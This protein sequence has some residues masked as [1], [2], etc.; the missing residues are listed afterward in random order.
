MRGLVAMLGLVLASAPVVAVA[1]PAA[2]AATAAVP[3]VEGFH[4]A[5][6]TAMKGGAKLGFAGRREGLAAPVRAAFDLP[7]MAQL[8]VGPRWASLTPADRQAIIDAFANYASQFK[9][10]GGERFA[11]LGTGEAGR[12]TVL[13]RTQ[14]V[15]PKDEPVA[16]TYR[17]RQG[18]DGQ[19]RV[20]D[21]LLDG[22]VSQ[23]SQ[24]RAE[25]AAIFAQGGA[26]ALIKAIRDR[27][28]RLAAS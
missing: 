14:L 24:R 9:A 25:F 11:T 19:W 26:P 1:Q 13:V 28:A 16:F 8:M 18:A 7:G 3:P 10:F 12:G 17:L 4:A 27:T 2:M 20:I 5:L 15:L 6:I 23:I 21:I 22:T